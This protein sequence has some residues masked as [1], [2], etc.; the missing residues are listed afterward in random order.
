VETA[1]EQ[2]NQALHLVLPEM[3]LLGTVCIIFLTAPFLISDSGEADPG[4]RH[5][6]GALALLGLGTAFI[7]W[8]RTG[9]SP[10]AGGPFVADELAWFTRG[11]SLVGG[12]L[13]TLLLWNQIADDRAAEAHACLLAIVA[14]TNLVA[15][16]NDLVGLFLALELVS[17]PTYVLLYLPRRDAATR[18][19]TL[20]YFLLSVFSSA[21]VLYGMSWLYGAAGTTSLSGIRE[22]VQSRNPRDDILV[23]RVAMALLI[24]GLC[25]RVTAV[26]F[27][28]YAPDVFQGTTSSNAAVLSF[29]P[30]VVG[31][32][33]RCD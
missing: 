32:V 14:G 3:V 13:L 25:F 7:I 23:L 28:F 11:L 5:H 18:E 26:P 10:T 9:V 31:F 21:I 2:I 20:K 33:A 1:I 27:H 30:K 17:I 8:I 4:L 22:L 19:A 29:I 24:A 15:V 12:I 6:W 16:S